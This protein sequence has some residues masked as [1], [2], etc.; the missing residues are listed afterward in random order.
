MSKS[1]P[2]LERL[3]R[4]CGGDHKHQGLLS[5]RA[6]RAAFYPLPLLKAI[7]QGVA[8]TEQAEHAVR[9][10]PEQAYDTDLIMSMCAADPVSSVASKA[11]ASS[12]EN[13]D[14]PGSI[15][16]EGGGYVRINHD[17]KDV[18]DP[19]LDEYTREVLPHD[20]VRDA[21]KDELNYFNSKK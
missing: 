2:M 5:G 12:P 9:D 8:D 20:L 7:L 13:S 14:G 6:A 21:I 15:P 4:L 10:L 11:D 18:K 3:S 17:I 16:V 1:L 19:Y